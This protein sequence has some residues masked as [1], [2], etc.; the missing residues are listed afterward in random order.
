MKS[1]ASMR[2]QSHP[3]SVGGALATL[4]SASEH[5]LPCFWM[6]CTCELQL[7]PSKPGILHM[8]QEAFSGTVHSS[9]L[10]LATSLNRRMVVTLLIWLM[11]RRFASSC[12]SLSGKSTLSGSTLT[13]QSYDLYSPRR[14]ISVHTALKTPV[15]SA[16]CH[17]PP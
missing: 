16:V 2:L 15:F 4:R 17:L 13:T 7:W 8:P 9:C 10:P 14:T 1:H 12:T 6:Y 3:Q 11:G 5:V